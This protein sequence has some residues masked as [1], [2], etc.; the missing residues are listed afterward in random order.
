MATIRRFFSNCLGHRKSFRTIDITPNET[1]PLVSDPLPTP[2]STGTTQTQDTADPQL[3][4]AYYFCLTLEPPD[5]LHRCPT[6]NLT[7]ITC[8][9]NHYV[10]HIVVAAVLD[11]IT[12]TLD[13]QGNYDWE[14]EQGTN[15][16]W[17]STMEMS[18]WQAFI[19]R[20]QDN[21]NSNVRGRRANRRTREQRAWREIAQMLME[22]RVQ[23][24]W[25][26][27]L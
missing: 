25:N 13:R 4:I 19:L 6:R 17:G 5:T 21:W 24:S 15:S 27:G 9:R 10:Y 1:S 12:R 18:S 2:T 20:L 11:E 26:R 23:S 22:A 16:P 14:I 8:Q 3:R 7:C